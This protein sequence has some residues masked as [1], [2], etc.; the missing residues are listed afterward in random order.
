LGGE[1]LFRAALIESDV[2]ERSWRMIAP[3]SPPTKM[4]WPIDL[5]R[6]SRLLAPPEAI[7]TTALLPDHPPA[8]FTWRS[9]RH[10][11]IRVDGPERIHGEWWRSD[12]E[13]EALR[14]YFSVEDDAGARFW[15][16][17]S[18]IDNAA[19]WFMHGVF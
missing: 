15:L 17:R 14:D 2:P 3:L 5:P 18:G 1:K 11:V 10:R 4:T 8:L 13:I 16:F 19:R 6:P 9:C 12:R 7:E